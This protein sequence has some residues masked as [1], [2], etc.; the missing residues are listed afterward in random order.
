MKMPHDI[1]AH[2]LGMR[3]NTADGSAVYLAWN[4]EVVRLDVEVPGRK[5]RS[6]Y[7][8]PQEFERFVVKAMAFSKDARE[9][10]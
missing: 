3:I 9:D 6:V 10:G 7:F 8:S 5:T 2:R 1:V 4:R